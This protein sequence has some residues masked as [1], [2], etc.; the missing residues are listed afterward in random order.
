MSTANIVTE[1]ITFVS[2]L[3]RFVTSNMPWQCN[4]TSQHKP[5]KKKKEKEQKKGGC[6]TK[7]EKRKRKPL[8]RQP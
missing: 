6:V 4:T 1:I 2:N 3:M 7:E 5:K 8:N